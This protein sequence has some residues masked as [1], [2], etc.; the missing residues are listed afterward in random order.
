LTSTNG[1]NVTTYTYDS[2]NKM[3]GYTDGTTTASYVYNDVGDRVQETVN[4]V[5]TLYLTDTQNPTG[6]DQPLEA[7][8][9]PTA[10]PTTTYL[11]GD[12]V[13]G[14]TDAAGNVRYLLADGHGSTQALTDA[15]GTVTATFR[16]DAFGDALNFTPSSAGTVFLFG[17]DA[18]Y[19]AS[20]GLYLHGN[21]IRPTQGFLFIQR[22]TY[23]GNTNEPLTLHKYLYANAN[24]VS[25]NDP[26]GHMD[27]DDELL[28]VGFAEDAEASAARMGGKAMGLNR[29]AHKSN[30][31]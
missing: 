24:P 1:T 29:G 3:V 30:I 5:T 14:Q 20:S 6:Y 10:T 16:Y 12:R 4:G 25:K 11:L 17:G 27:E 18:I 2:R 15:S 13:F 23:P 26:S 19:D 22:D 31:N 9:S 21:G 8:S 28:E 7:K